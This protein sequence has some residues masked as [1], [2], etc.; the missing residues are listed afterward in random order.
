VG[1]RPHIVTPLF[2]ALREATEA[3]S[4]DVPTWHQQRTALYSWPSVHYAL[5]SRA[6]Y[7]TGITFRARSGYRD[8]GRLYRNIPAEG[9]PLRGLQVWAWKD[10]API[11]LPD[12]GGRDGFRST[13]CLGATCTAETDVARARGRWEVIRTA[14]PLE[15]RPGDSLTVLIDRRRA[16][17]GPGLWTLYAFTPS[18]L[19]VAYG[20]ATETDAN[21]RVQWYMDREALPGHN[22]HRT[23]QRIRFAG[24]D[25]RLFYLRGQVFASLDHVM[26]EA[27]G[28][29]NAFAFSDDHFRF[30]VLE[31]G[32][33]AFSD[34][35]GSYR[36]DLA[37]VVDRRGRLDLAAPFRLV[38]LPARL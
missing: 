12:T 9:L 6:S 34:A 23:T 17:G 32:T 20:P 15:G 13:A 27:D 33:L 5:V 2:F 31:G 7:H 1:Q 36:L 30:H 18:A 8:D 28:P 14:A 37:D 25:G 19:V 26:V 10:E 3:A 38:Q 21:L 16:D 11:I 4:A 35:S 24:R 29:M 22:V